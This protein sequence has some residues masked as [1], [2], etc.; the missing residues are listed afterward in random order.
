[1][2]AEQ[3]TARQELVQSLVS[4]H[5][6]TLEKL[7]FNTKRGTTFRWIAQAIY[8]TSKFPHAKASTTSAQLTRWL[9]DPEHVDEA[10]AED[11]KETIQLM[12]DAITA[13]KDCLKVTRGPTTVAPVDF[14][15]MIVLVARV[16]NK[17]PRDQLSRAI[18]MLREVARATAGDLMWKT[19]VIEPYFRFITDLEAQGTRL[20]NPY[21]EMEVDPP[22]SA[23]QVGA[24]GRPTSTFTV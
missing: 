7:D 4:D 9:A 15:M 24:G 11:I 3:K 21:Q 1:M 19:T 14:V 17:L 10:F 5:I 6:E 8:T 13:D 18:Q 12:L 20:L 16:K 22:S 2:K 23:V